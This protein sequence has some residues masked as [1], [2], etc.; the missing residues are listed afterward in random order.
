MPASFVG[1]GSGPALFTSR[2]LDL[3]LELVGGTQ[4]AVDAAHESAQPVLVNLVPS[5]EVVDDVRLGAPRLR[6][7]V[8]VG[9]LDVLDD[10]AVLVLAGGGPQ[11]HGYMIAVYYI[12]S[13]AVSC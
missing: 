11:V 4:D 3:G 7:T 10:G 1:S 8:V 13:Q 2:R 9:E 6:V 5:A 12:S